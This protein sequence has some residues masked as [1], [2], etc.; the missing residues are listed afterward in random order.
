MKPIVC[1]KRCGNCPPKK[2][3]KNGVVI[4]KINNENSKFIL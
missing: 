1:K 4:I 3:I 2:K